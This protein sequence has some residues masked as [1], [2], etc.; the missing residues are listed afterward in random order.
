MKKRIILR[1]HGSVEAGDNLYFPRLQVNKRGEIILALSKAK[2]GLT[3]GIFV[4][5]IHGRKSKTIALGQVFDDWEVCGEFEDY[6]GEVTVSFKNQVKQHGEVS[7]MRFVDRYKGCNIYRPWGSK[8]Y[9][10]IIGDFVQ[11]PFTSLRA[12]KRYINENFAA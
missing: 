7:G 1:N 4:G 11:Q 9:A 10:V 5:M 12:C 3:K 6:D 8:M 2:C